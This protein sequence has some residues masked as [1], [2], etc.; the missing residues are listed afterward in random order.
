MKRPPDPSNVGI[1]D[2]SVQGSDD[3]LHSQETV[4]IPSDHEQALPD[5]YRLIEMM[6][7]GGMAEVFLAED[8]RLHRRVAIKFLSG[9]FRKDSDRTR[10]FTREARAASALNHPN[11]L[12]IHDIS[13]N[14][15]AQFIVSE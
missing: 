4:V 6:G 1:A 7:R 8:T 2:D 15:R 5:H 12:I 11:I 10:R 14:E 9:E 3:D 13:E